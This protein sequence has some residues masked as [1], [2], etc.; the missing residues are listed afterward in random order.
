MSSAPPPKDPTGRQ[1]LLSAYKDVVE[2]EKQR[3][4]SKGEAARQTSNRL[5]ALTIVTLGLAVALSQHSKWLDP[6]KMPEESRQIR[7][8]SLRLVMGREI[9]GIEAWRQAHGG[10]L[11][12][13]ADAARTTL[14]PFK[15]Q[16]AN[17]QY[18][19]TGSNGDITLS[20]QSSESLSTFLGQS[21]EIVRNRGKQ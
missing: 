20:Y 16:I 18:T 15:Y 19:L 10:A 13:S 2:S 7:E 3:G 6:V 12:D 4:K 8:A 14:S 9:H 11:P 5:I 1:A 21:Y 17:G